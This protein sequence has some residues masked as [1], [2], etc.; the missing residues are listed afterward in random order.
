MKGLC[1]K[2]V[3]YTAISY[4]VAIYFF[5]AQNSRTGTSVFCPDK[6]NITNTQ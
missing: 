2:H 3:Q 1:A 4:V 6:M 5:G